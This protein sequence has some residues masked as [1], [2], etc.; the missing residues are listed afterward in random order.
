MG[1]NLPSRRYDGRNS[2]WN[3]RYSLAAR[4][5]EKPDSE[6]FR[7]YLEWHRTQP[8]IRWIGRSPSH[9]ELWQTDLT[10]QFDAKHFVQ[11]IVRRKHPSLL[12]HRPTLI[13]VRPD[14]GVFNSTARVQRRSGPGY[15]GLL[16]SLSGD[17]GAAAVLR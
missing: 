14:H 10:G 9:F 12:A 8:A 1:T 15:W 13:G 7:K 2:K 17:C 4:H 3:R 6:A 5:T 16:G 11:E